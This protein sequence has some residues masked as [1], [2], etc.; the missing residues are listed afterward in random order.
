MKRLAEGLYQLG[1]FPPD[2]INIYVMGGVLID[3]GTRFARGR[4][5]RRLKAAGVTP[6]AHALTHAHA[7]HQGASRAVCRAL[8]LP[9]WCSEGDAEAAEDPRVMLARMPRHP[10]NAVFAANVAGPGCPVARRLKEG[11]EVGGFT[12]L[13]TPGH[14]AG[15]VSYWRESDRVLVI[16]DVVANMNFLTGRPSLREP[17]WFFSADPSRNRDSARR[18]AA[19]EP[20]LIAFGHGPP[21]RD[22]GEFARFAATLGGARSE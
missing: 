13:A 2:A 14:T 9:F 15:H 3:A 7:D 16:G 8:G 17:P 20:S 5:L 12:V 4:V 19:L 18:L 6:S 21:L 22:P 1:G 11:D 10:M